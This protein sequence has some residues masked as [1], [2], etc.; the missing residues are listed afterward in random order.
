[1]DAFLW[2][3]TL[4]LVC[5][6]IGPVGSSIGSELEHT[7]EH[8]GMV[9]TWFASSKVGLYP[10]APARLTGYFLLFE[11]NSG[12]KRMNRNDSIVAHHPSLKY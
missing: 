8:E 2:G 3:V 6:V 9:K 1:M 12:R 11:H 7:Q 5:C 10:I 4:P